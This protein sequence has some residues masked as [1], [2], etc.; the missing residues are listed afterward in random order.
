[1]ITLEAGV[2]RGDGTRLHDQEDRLVMIVERVLRRINPAKNE[3]QDGAR[4]KEE[5]EKDRSQ[6]H[7]R[8][9]R[10]VFLFHSVEP[11]PSYCWKLVAEGLGH[12][13]VS[14]LVLGVNPSARK[15]QHSPS[16]EQ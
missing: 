10:L 8:R 15:V 12:R 9:R 14:V 2:L 1:M 5:E 16:V 7:S 4:T 6:R 3:S 13:R 11:S